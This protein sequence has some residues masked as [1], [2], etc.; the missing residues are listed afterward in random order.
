MA[1]SKEDSRVRVPD[2]SSLS[3]LLNHG[4]TPA[5]LQ[6]SSLLV[7]LAGHPL[8]GLALPVLVVAHDEGGVDLCTHVQCGQII[9]NCSIGALYPFAELVHLRLLCP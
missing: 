2:T 7:H 9:G 8:A 3:N 4:R 1:V 5:F 6:T